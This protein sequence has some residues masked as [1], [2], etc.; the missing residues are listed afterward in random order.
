MGFLDA[1]PQAIY[2]L[3]T[4]VPPANLDGGS[5]TSTYGGTFNFD[6]GTA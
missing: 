4:D 3:K 5:A 6:G 2:A 1:P